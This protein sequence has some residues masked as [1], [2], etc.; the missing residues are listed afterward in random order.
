MKLGRNANQRG[1][2]RV[3]KA[4]GDSDWRMESC[5]S[6]S[7]EMQAARDRHDRADG[8]GLSRTAVLVERR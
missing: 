7:D 2:C 6:I 1:M 8:T 5:M 3:T 4:D